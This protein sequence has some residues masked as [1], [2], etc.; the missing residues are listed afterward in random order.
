MR[1]HDEEADGDMSLEEGD[2]DAKFSPRDL[3]HTKKR[4]VP[5][6]AYVILGAAVRP[7]LGFPCCSAVTIC[8][9]RKI[10]RGT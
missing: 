8:L 6:T 1:R 4:K 10:R 3:V 7:V 5:V 2:Q 9:G